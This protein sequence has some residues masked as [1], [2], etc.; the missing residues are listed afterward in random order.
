MIGEIDGERRH[1]N[2]AFRHG[3]KIRA[4]SRI[5]ARTGRAHPV[6]RPAA[7]IFGP[8]HGLGA[9]AIAEARDLD[10]LYLPRREYSAR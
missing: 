1:R 5:L 3:V 10:A 8:D 7:R 4:G 6:D 9:M 2:E